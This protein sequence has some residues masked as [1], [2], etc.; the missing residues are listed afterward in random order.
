MAAN[1]SKGNCYLCGRLIAKSAF[2]KH[3][4]TAHPYEGEASQDCVVLK[5]EDTDSKMYWLYLDVPATSTLKT[6]D[7]FLRKIWLECCGHMSEFF[8][9]DYSVIGMNHKIAGFPAGS[10]LLY[11]YDFGD[12][13]QLKITVV[14]YSKRPKQRGAVRL[15]G[16]NKAYQF[17]CGKCGKAADWI[18]CE[19][20]WKD[21][22]PFLCEACSEDHEY[23]SLLPIVNSPR[24]G[25]CAYCGEQDIYEFDPK[26]FTK[27]PR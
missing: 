10:C 19:G 24:M 12:T 26:S 7:T 23:D 13:T 3:A 14:G 20:V 4:L 18:C 27:S 8:E 1:T 11:E 5:V 17:A 9:K 21:V 25:V 16:R 2:K 6:L 15:L 22:N